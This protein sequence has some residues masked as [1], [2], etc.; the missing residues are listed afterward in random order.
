M[1]SLRT[2]A[3]A[4][5]YAARGYI[6]M[7]RQNFDG[8]EQQNLVVAAKQS[9]RSPS[10][11]RRSPSPPPPPTTPAEIKG[12]MKLDTKTV[13]AVTAASGASA[14]APVPPPRREPASPPPSNSNKATTPPKAGKPSSSSPDVHELRELFAAP[15][16]PSPPRATYDPTPAAPPP[17]SSSSASPPFAFS[18]LGKVP[19]GG[20]TQAFKA[21][22][23]A[24]PRAEWKPLSQPASSSGASPERPASPLTVQHVRPVVSRFGEVQ[25]SGT[26]LQIP[27]VPE[28]PGGRSGTY[29][30]H[31]SSALDVPIGEVI[32]AGIPG[33]AGHVPSG[34]GAKEYIVAGRANHTPQQDDFASWPHH[35]KKIDRSRDHMPSKMPVPGFAGHMHQTIDSADTYG[36]S[37]FAPKEAPSRKPRVMS[38][39]AYRNPVV[40]ADMAA[41]LAMTSAEVSRKLAA[42]VATLGQF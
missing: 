24:S 21:H 37:I 22:L 25:I 27:I 38:E 13:N 16:R 17:P 19:K 34:V 30:S 26:S 6:G 18:G 11:S 39:D 23:A 42:S 20:Y 31:N 28:Q 40:K 14:P 33:S 9:Q 35:A 29:L 3:G 12:K 32:S 4:N 10:P 7:G 2:G 41:P 5:P 8:Y 1:S 15:P 36:T